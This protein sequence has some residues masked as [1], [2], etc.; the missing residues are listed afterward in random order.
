MSNLKFKF[1]MDSSNIGYVHVYH[2]PLNL[3]ITYHLLN[4]YVYF[5]AEI[6]RSK[7]LS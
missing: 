6:Q 7:Y 4:Q 2:P 3:S 1:E 5:F